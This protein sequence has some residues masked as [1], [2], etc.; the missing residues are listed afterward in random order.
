MANYNDRNIYT[1]KGQNNE[2]FS[3]WEE[4]TT[5]QLTVYTEPVAKGRPRF[6][7]NGHAYTPKRTA[8]YEKLIRDCWLLAHGKN[9]STGYIEMSCDFYVPIPKSWS[10]AKKQKAIECELR[11]DKKPDIDN[12]SKAVKDA[13]NEVA[14]WDDAQIVTEHNNKWYSTEPR[15]E[16]RVKELKGGNNAMG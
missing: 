3:S 10:K 5:R 13:L 11:P 15:V 1:R 4:F 7:K 14:Y 6:T 8:D 16:I 12:F 9:I 2:L